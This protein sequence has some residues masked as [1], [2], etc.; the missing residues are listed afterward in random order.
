MKTINQTPTPPACLARQP[1]AQDW[2]AFMQTTCHALVA[3]SLRNEQQRLCCYCET[4]IEASNSHIEHLIPRAYPGAPNPY[5]YSNLASSCNGGQ[6]CGHFKDDRHRNPQ[7]YHHVPA[8]FSSPHDPATE[9]LFEYTARGEVKPANGLPFT[10]TVKANYMIK[11]IGLDGSALTG[12]RRDHARKLIATLGKSPDLPIL[13]W[14][15]NY[16]LQ[17][18]GSG[19]LRQFHSLSH[20]LLKA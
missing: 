4:E 12:R 5:Q 9:S 16:Y 14:A 18:D 3:D 10:E 1:Q 11:H 19:N 2:Y 15:M 20:T 6:H 17:P 7:H 8:T 13:Q